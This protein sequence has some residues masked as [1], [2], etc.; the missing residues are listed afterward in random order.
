MPPMVANPI[1]SGCMG[2]AILAIS[3]VH[4]AIVDRGRV[5]HEKYHGSLKGMEK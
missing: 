3:K 5:G 2:A 1:H 4:V